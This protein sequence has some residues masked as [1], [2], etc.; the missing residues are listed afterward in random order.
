MDANQISNMINNAIISYTS[1]VN[2]TPKVGSLVWGYYQTQIIAAIISIVAIIAVIVQIELNRRMMVAT[3][4]SADAVKEQSKKTTD[5]VNLMKISVEEQ[6]KSTRLAT[7]PFFRLEIYTRND[8][9]LN[10]TN[11]GNGPAFNLHLSFATMGQTVRTI[12]EVE[13]PTL[14]QGE[15]FANRR[16]FRGQS[17]TYECLLSYKDHYGQEYYQRWVVTNQTGDSPVTLEG[18]PKLVG[19]D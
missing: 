13:I 16:N 4:E 10:L 19:L 6:I 8:I 2:A 12:D 11:V 3:K 5:Q 15:R 17:N 9:S 14:N 7:L 18:P 1:S